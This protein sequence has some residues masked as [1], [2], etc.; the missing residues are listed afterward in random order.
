M[1]SHALSGVTL[2]LF[3]LIKA[4]YIIHTHGLYV[5]VSY[6]LPQHHF[7]VLDISSFCLIISVLS[8]LVVQSASLSLHLWST[9]LLVNTMTILN[10]SLS[11]LLTLSIYSPPD[12]HNSVVLTDLCG[13]GWV[14]CC[15][16][17]LSSLLMRLHCMC[18]CV[19]AF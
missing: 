11:S 15:L 1:M 5:N 9:S 13:C 17:F 19:N 6:H 10:P 8:Q 4:V 14:Y 16:P 3:H 12:S 18:V 2:S 7:L